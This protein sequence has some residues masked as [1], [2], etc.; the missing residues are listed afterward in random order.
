MYRTDKKRG[1]N[2]CMLNAYT[3]KL[4]TLDKTIFLFFQKGLGI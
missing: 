2:L 1:K 4:K 3:S